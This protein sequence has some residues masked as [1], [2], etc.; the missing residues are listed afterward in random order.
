M[1]RILITGANSYIGTSFEGYIKK[2]YADQYEIDTV[3]MIDGSW[4]E[5]SFAGYDVVFH[6][7]GI[8]H[9]KETKKNAR[10]YYKVNR[11]LVIATA[12]K[13]KLDGAKQFIFMSSMSVYGLDT[14]V[15]TKETI[16]SPKSN[17][18]KSKFQAELEISKFADKDFFVSILRPPMI[19]GKDC[20]GNFQSIVKL[21]RHFP[22]FPDINNQRSMIFIDNLSE[23]IVQII[24]KE[25]SGIILPQNR[26]KMNTTY[27]AVQIGECIDK[28]IFKSKLLGAIVHLI[29]P[30]SHYAKKAFGSLIYDTDSELYD[31]V[32]LTDSIKR[33]VV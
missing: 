22:F 19:Y 4:R 25:T 23:A 6:V 27:L 29:I 20:K 32:Q 14:G 8:A 11:D 12:Q 3:D 1:K 17:Y 16:P 28:R 2:N 33:S 13:A 18:G 15:I 31:F 26:E 24:E 7:A 30:F 9:Q 5:K 21:V 10:L